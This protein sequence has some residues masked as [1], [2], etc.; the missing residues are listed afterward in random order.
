MLAINTQI[1][2]MY[3]QLYGLYVDICDEIYM[4]IYAK[5]I[6]TNMRKYANYIQ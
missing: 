2:A 6:C 1:Y 5:K 3:M 4:Q